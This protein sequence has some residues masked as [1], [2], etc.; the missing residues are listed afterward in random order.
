MKMRLVEET[1]THIL[2]RFFLL[3]FLFGR[4]LFLSGSSAAGSGTTSSRG[5]STATAAARRNG[6]ELCSA[7]GNQLLQRQSIMLSRLLVLGHCIPH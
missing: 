1:E 4:L 7:F 6:C 2:V 5:C 3:L